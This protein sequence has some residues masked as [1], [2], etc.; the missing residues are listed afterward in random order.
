MAACETNLFADEAII[1]ASDENVCEVQQKLQNLKNDIS[2]LY[3]G[4][5]LT[6]KSDKYQVMLV[7]NKAQLKPLNVDKFIFNYEGTPLDVV[8][9]DKYLDMSMSEISMRATAFYM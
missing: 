3:Q 7:E 5:R 8:E 9:N 2:K 6:I 1:H 4:N